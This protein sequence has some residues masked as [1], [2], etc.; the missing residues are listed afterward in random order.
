MTLIE[1][2]MGS[3]STKPKDGKVKGLGAIAEIPPRRIPAT[4][5]KESLEMPKLAGTTNSCRLLMF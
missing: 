5:L 3:S 2:A 1:Q 4:E